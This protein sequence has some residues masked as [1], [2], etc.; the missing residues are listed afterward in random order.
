MIIMNPRIATDV[1]GDAYEYLIKQFADSTN[2]KAGEFYMQRSVDHV[3]DAGG[4]EV[5]Q[6]HAG[7]Q[8]VRGKIDATQECC[9]WSKSTDRK[10]AESQGV[11]EEYDSSGASP[12]ET[13]AGQST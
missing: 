12:L 11:A 10:S 13:S 4:G 3:Q 6:T 2:R 5:A 8:L 7:R 9:D 1:I